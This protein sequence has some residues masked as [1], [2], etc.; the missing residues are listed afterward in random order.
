MDGEKTRNNLLSL[1]FYNNCNFISFY[2]SVS[3]T[4]Y[5]FLIKKIKSPVAGAPR[6]WGPHAMAQMAQ[7]VIRPCVY[8]KIL[9]SHFSAWCIRIA[10]VGSFR[11]SSVCKFGLSG[12][13]EGFGV[14]GESR[15]NS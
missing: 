1:L 13:H 8:E 3:F 9:P 10:S 6:R 11:P 14:T 2:A 5:H 4:L 12:H 7:W 15:W